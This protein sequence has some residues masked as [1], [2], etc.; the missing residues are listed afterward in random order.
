[1][2]PRVITIFLAILALAACGSSPSTGAGS[3]K[4]APKWM[5]DMEADYPDA[6]FLTAVGSGSSR[7]AAEDDATGSLARQF[8]VKVKVDAVAQKRYAEIV[9]GDKSYTESEKTISQ[10]VGTQANEQFVN[11]RFSDP[12]TDSRG[13]THIVAYIER[14]PTAAIYRTLIQK[15]L[16][17]VDDFMDR[18]KGMRG[19]I[20]RYAFYDGAYNVGLNAERMIGQL[21][22][23]HANTAR[24][25][26][27]HLDLKKVTTARDAEANKMTYNV[28][29]TG[30]S[31][32][33]VAG[34]V[35]KSLEGMSLS[36][37]DRGLLMVKGSWKV[38]P[39]TVNPQFKSV[40][41]T[42]DMSLYD[43]TGAAIATFA[44]QSRE[45][46]INETQATTLAYRELEKNLNKD[47][48]GSI[49]GYLTRIVTGG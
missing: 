15:D 6:K 7:R 49:Q 8:T 11:L 24:M 1:M 34:I 41:W 4:N 22:I 9:K 29:I 23:I 26:E 47:F 14:E 27:S 31:D 12:Y 17:K 28:A 46:A 48:I 10:S 2:K 39:V 37:Q 35:R 19:T 18:A 44:K 20:Q 30:D 33:R 32:Q 40:Q 43:E 3:E 25:M 38:V 16:A 5:T 45:N 42:A 36:Y 13:T 21:R